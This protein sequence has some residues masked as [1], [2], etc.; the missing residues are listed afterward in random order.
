MWLKD[1]YSLLKIAFLCGALVDAF[2]LIPMV[3]PSVA[4]I[5]WGFSIFNDEYLFAMG[6][7]ATFMLGWTILLIWAFIKP[8]DRR[9]VAPLTMVIILG[10]LVTEI[11]LLIRGSIVLDVLFPSWLLKTVLFLLFGASYYY[12]KLDFVQRHKTGVT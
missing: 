6:Y 8:A 11:S 2:A 10:F 12:T 9:F 4:T 7:G 1:R 5:I 3:F